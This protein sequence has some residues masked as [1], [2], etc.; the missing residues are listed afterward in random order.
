VRRG[1]NDNALIHELRR[2][3]VRDLDQ[4]LIALL[5]SCSLCARCRDAAGGTRL[6]THDARAGIR[7]ELGVDILA[8]QPCS[9]GFNFLAGCKFVETKWLLGSGCC[10]GKQEKE[11]E[12]KTM[13]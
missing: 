7:Q 2:H 11:R 9:N 4:R 5:E 10:P 3:I 13:Q 1:A 8:V 6:K 12:R